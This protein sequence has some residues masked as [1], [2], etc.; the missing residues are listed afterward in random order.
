[1][2]DGEIRLRLCQIIGVEELPQVFV[3][4]DAVLDIRNVVAADDLEELQDGE[5]AKDF[6]NN[7]RRQFWDLEGDT[8]IPGWP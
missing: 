3:G 1:M 8:G 6:V 7:F 5:V 2:V 4:A